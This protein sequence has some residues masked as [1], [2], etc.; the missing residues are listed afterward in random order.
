[1]NNN[2][3]KPIDAFLREERNRT[4]VNSYKAAEGINPG[5]VFDPKTNKKKQKIESRWID[6][7]QLITYAVIGSVIVI[8]V[9]V[10]VF[11]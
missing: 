6:K 7:D 1:M 10:F 5:D 8:I 3:N 11:L 2:D 9:L 4:D